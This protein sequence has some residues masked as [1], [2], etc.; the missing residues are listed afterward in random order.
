MGQGDVTTIQL[1]YKVEQPGRK[2]L[3]PEVVRR[4]L[5]A[6]A[7]GVKVLKAVPRIGAFNITDPTGEF[8]LS[9]DD[10][11]QLEQWI[12]MIHN[13]ADEL[14]HRG[15]GYAQV[16]MLGSKLATAGNPQATWFRALD[17]AKDLHEK[18]AVQRSF[19]EW[20][21]GDSIAAHI[22]YGIDIFCTEDKG[23]SNAGKSVLDPDNREWLSN[24]YKVNFMTIEELANSLP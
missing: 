6:K 11:G 10:N 7:L 20:A 18:R 4:V 1:T 22:A 3:H 17:A 15:V 16:T 2:P 23:N 19:R 13:V 8:Y 12:S 21:D 5:A 24:T 14:D 9:N